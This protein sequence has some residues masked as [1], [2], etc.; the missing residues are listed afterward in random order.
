MII[1]SCAD[2]KAITT[3]LLSNVLTILMR[4]IEKWLNI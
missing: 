3:L 2:F 1:Q 4:L